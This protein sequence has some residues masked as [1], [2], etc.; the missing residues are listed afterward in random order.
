MIEEGNS[1]TNYECD[2]CCKGKYVDRY[3]EP[4]FGTAI[5][6][7]S[8]SDVD[9]QF[10]FGANKDWFVCIPCGQLSLNDIADRIA[11]KVF[12]NKD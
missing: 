6:Y 11:R 12:D 10:A 1:H 7:I 3:G 4:A 2:V 5:N 9:H 8:Y